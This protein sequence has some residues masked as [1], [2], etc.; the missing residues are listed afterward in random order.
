MAIKKE[1]N[2]TT[3]KKRSFKDLANYKK[4]VPVYFEGEQIFR[5]QELNGSQLSEFIKVLFE[6]VAEQKEDNIMGV[7]QNAICWLLK[8]MILDFDDIKE[9]ENQEIVESLNETGTEV[10]NQVSA[11]LKDMVF[12]KIE[13]MFAQIAEVIPKDEVEQNGEQKES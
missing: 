1:K 7:S 6:D 4:I 10:Q 5:I 9:M 3:L 13:K 8:T 12:S 11:I 2:V